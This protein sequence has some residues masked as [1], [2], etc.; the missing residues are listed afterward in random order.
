MICH[1]IVFCHVTHFLGRFALC[2]GG[3][4]N[5]C[6]CFH[7][8][9]LPDEFGRLQ[10]LTIHTETMKKHEK[11]DADVDLSELATLT[12]NFSGAEIEGLVRAAQSTAMNRLIKVR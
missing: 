7:S 2:N 9:G 3:K 12:K 10:I 1:A 11:L 4:I 8:A 5:Y 6:A